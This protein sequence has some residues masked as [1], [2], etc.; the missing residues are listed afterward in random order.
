VRTAIPLVALR[1]AWLLAC[2]A[3]GYF[4]SRS[5]IVGACGDLPCGLAEGAPSMGSVAQAFGAGSS[6]MAALAAGVAVFL[7]GD[8]LLFAGAVVARSEGTGPWRAIWDRGWPALPA[9]LRVAAVGALLIALAGA[10]ARWLFRLAEGPLA[11]EG[12]S[13]SASLGAGLGAT[14]VVAGVAAVVGAGVAVAKAIVVQDRRRFTRRALVLAVRAAR[15][16]PGAFAWVVALPVAADLLLV[17]LAVAPPWM[18]PEWLAT[19]WPVAVLVAMVAWLLRVDAC[20]RVGGA[21]DRGATPDRPW[22]VASR[23][24]RRARGLRGGA[25]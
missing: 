17:P 6:G 8:Q 19:T 5:A 11:R 16:A 12:A 13:L 1:F 4:A 14:V 20:V 15:R 10:G 25:G 21:V 3:P 18:T 7:L 24:W 2:T 9:L 22:G 23:L